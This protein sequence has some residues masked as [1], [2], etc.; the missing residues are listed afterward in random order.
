MRHC[1]CI[2][3]TVLFLAGCA[4]SV[5]PDLSQ[6]RKP[7]AAWL[8]APAPLPEVVEHTDA[9]QSDANCSAQYVRETGKLRA[10]QGYAKRIT[11]PP[12]Q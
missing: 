8:E 3:L 11:T 1:S 5:Q 10:L 2:A 7:R 9:Y 6:L 4:N 12:K